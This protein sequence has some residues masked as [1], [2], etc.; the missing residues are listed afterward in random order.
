MIVESYEDVLVL[1]GSMRKNFWETIHT[2]ITLLVRRHP[3]GVIIDCSGI[4]EMTPEGATTFRDALEFIGEHDRARIVAA[5]VPPHALAALHSIPEL[6]DN[7][8]IS[9]TVEEARKSLDLLVDLPDTV[10]PAADADFHVLVLLK[11]SPTD[12]TVIDAAGRLVKGRKADVLVLYAEIVPEG[13]SL[14]SPQPDQ[15]EAISDSAHKAEKILQAARIPHVFR[16]ERTRDILPA[17][18]HAVEEFK[19]DTLLIAIPE[20]AGYL[21][22]RGAFVQ[23]VLDQIEC[24]IVFMRD[25]ESL[26]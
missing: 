18:T 16:V 5:S 11:G 3:T 9:D 8:G 17:L 19:P 20:K 10:A 21:K 7:L 1:S 25:A 4:T 15:E 6:K 22:D 2:A 14:Q 23:S 13:E 24:P 26:T 12:P